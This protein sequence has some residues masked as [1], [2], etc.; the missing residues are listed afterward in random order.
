MTDAELAL[1]TAAGGTLAALGRWAVGLWAA[2]RRE[3]IMA[4][5]E[6][7]ALQRAESGRM[8]EAL[9]EQARS[10]ATLAGKLEGLA[11][12]LDMLLDWPRERTPVEGHCDADLESER[13]AERRRRTAPRGYRPPRPGE[14]DDH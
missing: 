11:A 12:K 14:H 6:T 1:L 2:V 8:V 5:K 3:D 10:N 4:T 13:T 7:A 9:L